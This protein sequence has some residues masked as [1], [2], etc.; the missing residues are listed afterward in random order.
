MTESKAQKLVDMFYASIIF[1]GFF[2]AQGCIA[3]RLI[4]PWK[5]TGILISLALTV[6]FLP[7]PFVIYRKFREH[8][9]TIPPTERST[10]NTWVEEHL[11]ST[12]IVS[13]SLT[14]LIIFLPYILRCV[15][16]TANI[17][18]IPCG[19]FWRTDAYKHYVEMQKR[20]NEE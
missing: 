18:L 5:T 9:K 17:M 15:A 16:I 1:L 3:Y 19:F 11:R 4:L 20:R 8:M 12:V 10:G 6:V 13:I 2:T 7:V 14:I